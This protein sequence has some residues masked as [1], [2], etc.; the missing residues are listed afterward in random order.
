MSWLEKILFKMIKLLGCKEILEGVWVKCIDCDL[1][2]YKVE[3]EKVFNVCFKCDYYMCL[4][5]CKCLENFL[6]DVD[7]YEIGVEYE[8]KDVLKFK[9]FKKYFDCII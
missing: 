8:L 2:L 6:D 1:I 4:S 7:C 9:D 3:L 5:G